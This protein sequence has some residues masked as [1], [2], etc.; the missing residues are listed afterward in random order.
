MHSLDSAYATD[1]L[2]ARLVEVNGRPDRGDGDFVLYWMQACHRL[3]DN[4]AFRYA[5][6]EA[7]RLG[8]PLVVHQGLDPTYP[9]AS[10]RIHHFVLHGAR[11]TAAR[12]AELGVHYQFVLRRRR[13]DDR[14]V[15]DRIAGRAALVVTDLYPTAGVRERTAR[16]AARLPVRVV[17]VDGFGIVPASL[18][19]KEEYAAR[20]IR[21][22]LARVRAHFLEPV[23]TRGGRI[24]L[25][26]PAWRALGD[27]AGIAPIALDS[28]DLTAEI[29]ACEID[30]TVPP[31][32][33]VPGRAAALARLAHFLDTGFGAYSTRRREP[34]DDDGSSRLS[35]YLHF[36]HLGSA[37]L[38]RAVLERGPADQAEAYLDEACTWRELAL[39]YCLRNPDHQTLRALPAWARESLEAHRSDLREHLYTVGQLERGETHDRL[40]NAAQ[41]EL[42]SSGQ[43]H[44][45]MRQIW[46]KSV[47][48]WTRD[49]D[50]ALAALITLNDR[51][52]LDGRDPN[53]Y[54]NILWCF[55]KFDRP[56][57]ERPILGKIR[58]ISLA[59]A[60][61]KFDLDPYVAR[62]GRDDVP[63]TLAL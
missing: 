43:L 42:V 60:W 57:Q 1:Q 9:Y 12:A 3:D 8:K 51:W 19:P 13:S 22:K 26:A 63:L 10:D 15:V 11:E 2:A 4:W 48:L 20:T 53:S 7:D 23:E 49:A 16:L 21:P 45:T 25:P 28:A 56:F 46:G 52:A 30:H 34:A 59:R 50:D 36:G 24:P 27:E 39:N 35:P 33:L 54:T 29:A 32:P 14:R 37:E 6:R 61:K 44:N 18:F 62:W 47:L 40:W 41:Q 17:K 58:P 38:A 31:A 55:G 5:V